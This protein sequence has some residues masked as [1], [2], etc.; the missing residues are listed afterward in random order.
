M[1]PAGTCINRRAS[2]SASTDRPIDERIPMEAPM[3]LRIPEPTSPSARRAALTAAAALA[4]AALACGS[5]SPEA[6]SPDLRPTPSGGGSLAGTTWTLTEIRGKPPLGTEELTLAVDDSTA[7]GY[8]GC[9]YFGGI[10]HVTA[11]AFRLDDLV[12]TLRA[13]EDTRLMDQESDYLAIL[14]RTSAWEIEGARLHLHAETEEDLVF[15]AGA[16]D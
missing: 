13:C 8:S 16:G 3:T 5:T 1:V 14:A 9:N 6:T 12:S 15:R 4:A 10:P 2:G 7:G 11:G